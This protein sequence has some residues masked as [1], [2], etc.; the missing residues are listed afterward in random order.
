MNVLLH[1]RASPGF[2]DALAQACPRGMTLSVVDAEDDAGL[3]AALPDTDAILHVLRPLK[4]RDI[5]AAPRLRLIQKIG[6][7]VNTIDLDTARAKGVAVCNMP[8]TNSQAVAELALMLMLAA[9][10]RFSYFDPLTRRG[11]G[12]RPEPEHFDRV[13]EL[14]GRTVGLVGFGAIPQ[15]LAPVLRALGA[16]V[17]HTVARQREGAVSLEELLARS[18]VI[19]LHCPATPE[20]IGMISRAVLARMKP[21]AVLVNTARGELVDEAALYDALCSGHLRAAGLDVFQREPAAANTPLFALANVV[22]TPHVGWL[23]PETLA[24]SIAIAFENCRRVQSGEPLLH[25]VV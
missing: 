23:T 10:R 14:A 1:Y 6:I 24:R 17:I 8:G 7:G 9:L 20:T 18:D 22:V 15:R 2:R 12:W 25:R 3:A 11:G 16:E 21:G 4:A 19:S 13:G 5:G